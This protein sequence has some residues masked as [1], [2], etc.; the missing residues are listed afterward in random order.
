MSK[1]SES[2]HAIAPES[3]SLVVLSLFP[4]DWL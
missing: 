2:D 1:R 4:E 3:D